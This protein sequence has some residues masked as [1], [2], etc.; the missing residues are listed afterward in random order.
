MVASSK[1]LSVIAGNAVAGEIVRAAPSMLNEISSGPAL[2]FAVSM[3][4]LMLHC[5]SGSFASTSQT[6]SS[7]SASG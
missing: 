4:A 2:A 1:T 3:A 6:S 7:M 5:W